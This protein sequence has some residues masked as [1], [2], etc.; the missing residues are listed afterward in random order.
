MLVFLIGIADHARSLV[1]CTGRSDRRKEK[2]PKATLKHKTN[3]TVRPRFFYG[4]FILI[5][6]CINLSFWYLDA[7]CSAA[8]GVLFVWILCFI[9][10]VKTT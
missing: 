7:V 8:M 1:K 3:L 2:K 6:Y 10:Y 4:P 5:W 9:P